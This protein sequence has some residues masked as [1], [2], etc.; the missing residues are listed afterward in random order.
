[1]VPSSQWGVDASI[2]GCWGTIWVFTPHLLKPWPTL[3]LWL[4]MLYSSW[5]LCGMWW[6]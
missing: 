1:M 4:W 5:S 6:L 2:H 3:S